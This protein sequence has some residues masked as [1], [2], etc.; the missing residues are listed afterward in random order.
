[1]RAPKDILRPLKACESGF[2]VPGYLTKQESI[3][4]LGVL[5]LDIRSLLDRE[6]YSD[7]HGLAERLGISSGLWPLFG[8]LWPS[9]THLAA[10]IAKRA[11]LAT[12]TILEVGCGLA[13]A[14]LVGHRRG[15]NMTAS[16]VH[17]L[18]E[19]FLLENLRLNHLP[20]MKYRCGAWLETIPLLSPAIVA[21]EINVEGRFDLIIGSDLLYDRNATVAL[22]GFIGRHAPQRSEVW[23]ADPE[24]GNRPAFNLLMAAQGYSR[25]E[26]R[27]DTLMTQDQPAYK[28]RMLIYQRG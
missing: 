11:V 7:P 8:L 10:R 13:L 20:P 2:S 19:T 23:I 6:Q 4:V 12:E 21:A 3:A 14:S 9:G 27:L 25:H 1:L 15:A 24:R 5:N 26:E 16:D 22:A 17:P 28:G 18:T